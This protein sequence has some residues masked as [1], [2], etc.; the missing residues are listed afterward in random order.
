MS[1]GSKNPDFSTRTYVV[2]KQASWLKEWL[3]LG[4]PKDDRRSVRGA[5]GRCGGASLARVSLP[6]AESER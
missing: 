3:A 5:G 2:S 1:D 4:R 6:T